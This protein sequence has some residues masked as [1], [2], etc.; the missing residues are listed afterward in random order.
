MNTTKQN[1]HQNDDESSSQKNYENSGDE[2]PGS[3]LK[4]EEKE[5]SQWSIILEGEWQEVTGACADFTEKL[6]KAHP[7]GGQN[8]DERLQEWAKWSPRKED[9]EKELVKRTASQARFEPDKP[10]S[11]H[12]EKSKSH[13]NSLQEKLFSQNKASNLPELNKSLKRGIT[14]LVSLL[15]LSLGKIEE[16]LYRKVILR[17]N[18]FYFDNSLISASFKK[19]N[20]FEVNGDDR[21]KLKVKI[22][23]EETK[24][25]F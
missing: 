1:N 5:S 8:E 4:V 18:P 10:P 12:L 9:D 11:E 14:A 17:T 20:R 16:F 13:L 23:D 7:Q 15:G 25:N 24:E 21:Y 22:H 19:T 2:P 3:N 6:E